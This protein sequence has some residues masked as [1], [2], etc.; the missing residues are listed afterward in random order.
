MADRAGFTLLANDDRGGSNLPSTDSLLGEPVRQS[1]G[2]GQRGV[3]QLTVLTFDPDYDGAEPQPL[4]RLH[5]DIRS[6]R[7]VLRLRDRTARHPN[8]FDAFTTPHPRAECCL[9]RQF[10]RVTYSLMVYGINRNLF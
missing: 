4:V 6:W 2:Q 1:P 7:R 5:L 10:S 9:V 8:A 3:E